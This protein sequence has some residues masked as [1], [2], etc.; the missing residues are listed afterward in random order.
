MK[1]IYIV[2]REPWAYADKF[3]NRIVK[4]FETED[5]AQ[6]YIDKEKHPD[7]FGYIWVDIELDDDRWEDDEEV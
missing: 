1:R 2:I 3:V 4:W 6:Q 5:E 7:D